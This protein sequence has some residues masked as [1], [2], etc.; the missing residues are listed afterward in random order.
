[1]SAN[2]PS[3]GTADEGEDEK[4]ETKVVRAA[5]RRGPGR[6]SRQAATGKIACE[7]LM[8]DHQLL[9]VNHDCCVNNIFYLFF[10]LLVMNSKLLLLLSYR[11]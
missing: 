3:E 5:R 9:G 6:P 1:M 7:Q 8:I 4:V 2:D 11:V 10:F